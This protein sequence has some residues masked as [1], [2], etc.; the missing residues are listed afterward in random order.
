MTGIEIGSALP[1]MQLFRHTELPH[2]V[3]LTVPDRSYVSQGPPRLFNYRTRDPNVASWLPDELVRTT[4]D[5][6][7][8][9]VIRI[10]DVHVVHGQY[11]IQYPSQPLAD[12]FNF[13]QSAVDR[14]VISAIG[15][16]IRRGEVHRNEK[17]ALPIFHIFKDV[18][19]NYGHMLIEVLPKLL[20]IRSTG[21]SR[22]TLLFP[23]SSLMFLPAVQFAANA[24]GL[25]FEHVVCFNNQVLRVD[26]ALW[27]G[28]VAQ[29]DRRK[30]QTLREFA[31]LLAA[32][33][34]VSSFAR[35][36]YVTRPAGAIRPIANQ[37]DLEDLA[38]ARGYHVIEPATLSFPEQISAFQGADHVLGPMGAALANMVFMRPGARVSM[39]TNRRVDPFYFDLAR[40]MGLEFDW[41]FT[42]DAEAWT[43]VMQT[44]AW[45]V[46][47][48]R[49]AG[50]LPWLE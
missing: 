48:A 29:H 19:C 37:A 8:E 26:E 11:L 40:L 2:D 31:P 46:D 17:N 1:S 49:F 16:Q 41:I 39:F 38:R 12:T 24:L 15:Q 13:E 5:C 47:A 45:T 14:P 25:A 28:P 32:A 43:S 10:R 34:P 27:I 4:I 42:Q 3:V 7:D 21:V 35:R 20:H 44:E 33:A 23:W 22:F 36:L 18:Y 50:M 9:Y 6:P 30:S